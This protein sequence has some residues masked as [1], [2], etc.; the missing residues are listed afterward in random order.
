MLTLDLIIPEND[1]RL[2]NTLKNAH[3]KALSAFF[4][5]LS[6]HDLEKLYL[7]QTKDDDIFLLKLVLKGKWC[8]LLEGD[9]E[10]KARKELSNLIL[11]CHLDMTNQDKRIF[12]L[13]EEI[14]ATHLKKKNFSELAELFDSFMNDE[15][16]Y[17][18][19]FVNAFS[20]IIL[21]KISAKE[22]LE[23][24]NKVLIGHNDYCWQ[25]VG[26]KVQKKLGISIED[27]IP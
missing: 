24:I 1:G 4:G 11:G 3:D 26:E 18:S 2:N 8:R 19:Y 20:K 27:I 15:D 22:T 17:S 14:V 21:E 7:A 5:E 13:R 10:D 6:M 12:D 25:Q 16:E 23:D 9:D